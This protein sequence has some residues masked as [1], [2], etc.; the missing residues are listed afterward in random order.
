MTL[1]S[2]DIDRE[3][4][5]LRRCACSTPEVAR[6]FE[7]SRRDFFSGAE[8]GAGADEARRAARRHCEWFLL[9]RPSAKLDAVPIEWARAHLAE[10]DSFQLADENLRTLLASRCSV[11]EVTGVAEGEGLWV[12]DLA[13]HGEYPLYE[14]EGS[15]A[16][17][18]GDVIVGR[19]FA[20]GDALFRVSPAAGVFRSE[21]LLRA[22]SKD[23]EDLRKARRGVLRLSQAELETMFWPR[24]VGTHADAV[25]LARV[26]LLKSGLPTQQVD[27]LLASLAAMPFAADRVVVGARD[28][29]G[30]ILDQL[31]FETDIDMDGARRV[32]IAAWP[33]LSRDVGEN[34][35]VERPGKRAGKHA[36]DPKAA[37]DAFDR[38]RRE[39]HDLEQLFRKL[40][41]DLEL[42][43]EAADP[44]ATDGDPAPDFP[45]VV[46]ALVTEF[47]W[48]TEREQ[49][50]AAAR[51]FAGVQAFADFARD[52]G[53]FD[54]MGSRELVLFAAVW[55]PERRVLRNADE[56][57]RMLRALR[58]F[59]GWSQTTQEVPL[60]DA[61]SASI[62]PLEE[63][64]PRLVEANRW[65]PA[66]ADAVR[67]DIFEFVAARDQS[68]ALIRD[69][70]GD[71]FPVE[72]D[73]RVVRALRP[74]DRLR[75][76]RE[77]DAFALLCCYPAESALITP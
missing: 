16:L 41:A 20:I 58:A 3:L 37:I 34:A 49:G 76:Q 12:H 54:N 24:A 29:L 31:A 60:L 66:Q 71:E 44:D 73:T 67:S 77:S 48:E 25:E 65:C 5:R 22:L 7:R 45:G 33:Q 13:A 42:E 61:Y 63:S 53:V 68:Q 21:H 9:E 50:T 23:T 72:L 40:E 47:L 18:A 26:F 4:D 30:E 1:N 19:L 38:G 27:D 17:A 36:V 52:Y 74:G 39:G 35:R 69:R 46:G 11:F 57:T 14:P 15:R 10:L 64:L 6:E 43:V 70:H 32:L 8:P 2:E 62:Q 55:L 56:A 28:A 59:C 51:E 75:A